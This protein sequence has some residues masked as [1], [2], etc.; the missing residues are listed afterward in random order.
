[1]KVEH[2]ALALT[3]L[4]R[5]QA[6]LLEQRN[7]QRRRS[8]QAVRGGMLDSIV[9]EGGERC[10]VPGDAGVGQVEER[11]AHLIGVK[12]G[13]AN[14]LVGAYAFVGVRGDERLDDA[15]QLIAVSRSRD[16]LLELLPGL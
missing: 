12:A 9:H 11:L 3:E 13:V 4:R 8:R 2:G 15:Q 5:R 16:S 10:V 7:L 1:A 14:Q 6:Q